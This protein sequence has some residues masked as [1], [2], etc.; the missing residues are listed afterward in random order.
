MLKRRG[1]V[2]QLVRGRGDMEWW[3]IGGCVRVDC[4]YVGQEG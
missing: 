1:G 2:R 3:E 4:V